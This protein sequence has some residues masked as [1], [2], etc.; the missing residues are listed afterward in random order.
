MRKGLILEGGSMRGMFTAGVLDVFMENDIKFDGVIG[1]SAGTVFGCNYKSH[2]KGRTIRYN[3][4]HCSDYRYGS[5]KSWLKTGDVFD[6]ELCY[7]I[8]PYHDDPFDIETYRKDPMEFYSTVTDIETGEAVYYLCADGGRKDLKWFQASASMPLVSNTVYINDHGYLD[9]GISD[10]I[11]LKAMEEKGYD[12][13][14]CVLTRPK[15]YRKKKQIGLFL[16]K[17]MYKKYPKLVEAMAKRHLEYNKTLDYIRGK[18]EKGEVFV[19]R[20]PKAIEVSSLESDPERLQAA[21]DM[22][23]ETASNCLDD[24]KEYLKK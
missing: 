8:I 4:K 2:Q 12:R 9:G 3:K 23:R 10:S 20:P 16:F 7:E 24:L 11:P 1:V 6:E 14:V 15:E 18:E 17:I 21:Y 5:F 22:G 19:I 13:N